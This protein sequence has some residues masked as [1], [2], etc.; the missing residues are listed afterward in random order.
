MNLDSNNGRVISRCV[1]FCV[2][3]CSSPCH[4]YSAQETAPDFRFD[5]RPVLAKNCFACHGPD[6]THREAD[7]RLDK[8]DAAV[9]AGAIVPGAPSDS[10]LVHRILSRDPNERMPPK[11]TGH[12]LSAAEIKSI[13]KWIAA[14]A[15]YSPHWAYIPPERPPLP[16]VSRPEWCRNAIDYFVLARLD[17]TGLRPEP[18]ADRYRLI[19]RV[20]LDLTGLP[21]TVEEAD[22][23]ARDNRSDA[24]ERLVDRLLASP[25]YGE[26]WARKWLDLARYAD[27]NGY[28]KDGPRTVWPFRDW[29]IQSLNA[30]MPFDEFT[31]E[32][33]AGD[34]LPHPTR[35]QII[36]TAFHRNTMQN[37]EGGTDNEEF[38]VTA[39]IDRVNTTMQVWMATTIG[40]CQCHSHKYDP[41]S[42]RE[43][44]QLFAFFNQS[45]DADR[46]DGEPLL[47]SWLKSHPEGSLKSGATAPTILPSCKNCSLASSGP[48]TSSIA[49]SF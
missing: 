43:Y 29:V 14:G 12:T 22:A 46:D 7:L 37:D 45:A 31:I 36:A 4:S 32:Q 17:K 27:T 24:Y 26:H 3:V 34:L 15:V 41:F 21:P 30:D 16:E 48:R 47:A 1:F 39:V 10:E 6:E 44:Y 11:E 5:I 28:E 13:K 20:S 25:A 8:R 19:R 9:E 40:C 18:E 23:F 38:R 49:A 2:L 33:L 42:Q 35:D